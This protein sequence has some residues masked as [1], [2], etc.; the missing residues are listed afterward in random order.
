MQLLVFYIEIY[1]VSLGHKLN[2]ALIGLVSIWGSNLL[3]SF[4]YSK[5]LWTNFGTMWKLQAKM[6]LKKKKELELNG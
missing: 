1:L 5:D 2:I 6:V 3:F 4:Y